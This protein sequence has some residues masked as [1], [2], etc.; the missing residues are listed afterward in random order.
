M[1]AHTALA[2]ATATCSELDQTTTSF[3]AAPPASLLNRILA[4]VSACSF[5]IVAPDLPMTPPM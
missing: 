2:P 5:L 4:P 1:S 3:A